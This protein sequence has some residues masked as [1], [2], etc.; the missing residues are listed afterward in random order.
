[1]ENEYKV[2]KSGPSKLRTTAKS[3]SLVLIGTLLGLNLGGLYFQSD[4]TVV[5][6]PL[7]NAAVAEHT[8]PVNYSQVIKE[9][10]KYVVSIYT[11]TGMG[12][13]FI[14]SDQGYVI[15]NAHVATDGVKV[16]VWTTFGHLSEGTIVGISEFMDIALVHVPDYIDNPGVTIDE[17]PVIQA[18]MP[19]L[20][21]S[22]PYGIENTASL[23]YITGRERSLE[24]ESAS[25]YN[26]FIQFDGQVGPGSSGGPLFDP[27]TGKVVGVI[28]QTGGDYGE[29]K[30]AIPINETLFYIDRWMKNP[31]TEEEVE[32][33]QANLRKLYE[34]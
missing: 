17:A 5:A 8:L 23:G 24:M 18:G 11:D 2:E 30:Y 10:D 22:A 19:I 25:S 13:G 3:L 33:I 1:M 28:T 20:S 16:D 31:M 12:S 7:A 14:Y 15:T 27:S 9:L 4:D 6:K 34:W 26:Q 32:L 29:I 21:I